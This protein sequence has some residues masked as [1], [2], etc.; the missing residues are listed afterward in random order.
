MISDDY[1]GR[2]PE[3]TVMLQTDLGSEPGCGAGACSLGAI[4][5]AISAAAF[6]GSSVGPVGGMTQTMP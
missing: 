5:S 4:A 6:N 3:V 1:R 2:G